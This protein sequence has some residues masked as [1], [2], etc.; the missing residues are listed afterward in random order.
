M[1]IWTEQLEIRHLPILK[2]WIGRESGVMTENDLPEDTGMLSAWFETCKTDQ[3]RLDC[4]V[5]VYETPVGIAG[6]IRR[7]ERTAWMYLFLGEINYNSVRTATY[8]TL[9]MLD[10]A[11]L[12]NGYDSVRIKVLLRHTEY[13]DALVQMGFSGD[14]M[15]DGYRIASV[16]KQQFLSRKY[17]F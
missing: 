4:L 2:H 1:D 14:E 10:R 7:D 9:R 3:T 12:E 5:S 8:A 6:L 16:E 17:L 11:F 13:L 15:K